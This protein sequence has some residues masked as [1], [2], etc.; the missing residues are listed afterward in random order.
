MKKQELLAIGL[1]SG[2]KIITDNNPELIWDL[3]AHMDSVE[4]ANDFE[5][6]S[7]SNLFNKLEGGANHKPV[8]YPLSD[9]E[10]LGLD[11]SDEITIRNIIDKVDI[12]DNI[13]FGLVKYLINEHFDIAGLI[14]KRDAVDVNTLPENPYKN[15]L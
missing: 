7:I 13:R 8:L 15:K 9:Y 5:H 2:L 12:I 14:E 10:K 6:I 4:I 1:W 3:H 11:I